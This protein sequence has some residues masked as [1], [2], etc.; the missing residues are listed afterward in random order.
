MGFIKICA[1][2]AVAVAGMATMILSSSALQ[3]HEPEKANFAL[4]IH[5]GAGTI[6][7]KNMTPEREASIRAKLEE[8][9]RAGQAVLDRGGIALDA[10]TAAI[11]VMENSPHFNAGKGAVFTHEGRNEMDASI[12]DG[13]DLN[14]GAVAGVT[15]VKNPIN[16]AREVMENSPHV[17]LTGAGAEEFGKGR[18]IEMVD[19]SYFRTERRWQQLQ[20]ALKKGK[21]S[22]DHDGENEAAKKDKIAALGYDPEDPDQK[23]GTVGAAAL[24]QHG[25]IAAGTSTGGMTNKRWNR[26]GDAPVIGAGTYADNKSC[27]VSATGHGEYFIRAA[28]AHSICALMEYKGLSLKDAADEIVMK[29]LVKMGGDGGIIALDAKG[30]ISMTFNTPGMYRGFVKGHNKPQTGIY[31]NE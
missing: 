15:H 18:N 29:K 4:V 30:N 7:K 22:L 23:F 9:L 19:P 16:L 3:A 1:T 14:A 26:I 25:N 27:A 5:G 10:V 2:R 11:N 20:N 21:V 13:R 31:K 17:M 28:V 12:M 8:A 24:D 6:L